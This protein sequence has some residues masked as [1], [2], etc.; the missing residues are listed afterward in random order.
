MKSYQIGNTKIVIYSDFVNLSKEEQQKWFDT[1]LK[2]G[3][4][5]VKEIVAAVNACYE[6]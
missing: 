6:K 2:K 1:E 4:P 3:N 5:I